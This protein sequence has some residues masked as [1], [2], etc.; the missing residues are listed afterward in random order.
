MK[1]SGNT[2]AYSYAPITSPLS[3]PATGRPAAAYSSPLSTKSR[4]SFDLSSSLPVDNSSA[5]PFAS[6]GASAPLGLGGGGQSSILQ[7]VLQILQS[8]LAL[9]SQ[10][11]QSGGNPQTG[12]SGIP[13]GSGDPSQSAGGYGVPGA[14]SQSAGGY[15]AP[16]TNS[17]S[18]GPS[19]NS[20]NYDPNNSPDAGMPDDAGSDSGLPPGSVG[21]AEPVSGDGDNSDPY[22]K[23]FGVNGGGH[24]P[25]QYNPGGGGKPGGTGNPFSGGKEGLGVNGTSS[26]GDGSDLSSTK[27]S[28]YYN[29]SPDASASNVKDPNATFIPMIWGAKN[30]NPKD[31]AAAKNSNSPMLLTFN[32]PELPGQANMSPQEALS[33]WGQLEATG[34]KLSSPAVSN[35][36]EGMQWL[37][38]FMQGAAASGHRVDSISLHWYGSSATSTEQNVANLKSHIEQVHQ[39][40]PNMPINLTEFGVDAHGLTS[41]KD[42]AFLTGAEKML[43]DLPYVQMY[44]PYGLGSINGN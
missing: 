8:V 21:P 1:L 34:K 44:S 24:K 3:Q 41:G 18:A 39:K 38:Q 17:Q 5:N 11:L 7:G 29:W 4:D 12:S 15:G 22:T 6:T 33:H 13:S 32:E 37:D 30:M 31:L 9:V 2:G 19:A 16:G 10:L 20:P 23:N 40:Y 42:Q 35:G 28:W 25:N 14:D 27:A 26:N 43:N 36:P